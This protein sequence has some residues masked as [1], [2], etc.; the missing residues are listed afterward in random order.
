MDFNELIDRNS[1]EFVRDLKITFFDV[2]AKNQMLMDQI[3]VALSQE[4]NQER[5]DSLQRLW[6]DYHDAVKGCINGTYLVSSSLRQLEECAHTYDNLFAEKTEPIVVKAQ[7]NETHMIE[8]NALEVPVDAINEVSVAEKDVPPIP[9]IKVPSVEEPTML[10]PIESEKLPSVEELEPVVE[11]PTIVQP[12]KIVAPAESEV[13]EEPT[14]V[15]SEEVPVASKNDKPVI[16]STDSSPNI[17][18]VSTEST[19]TPVAEPTLVASEEI[20]IIEQPIVDTL[21]IPV[22]EDVQTESV[23]KSNEKVQVDVPEI[24]ANEEVTPTE[25]IK[26]DMFSAPVEKALNSM[27]DSPAEAAGTGMFAPPTEAAGTGMFASPTEAAGTGMFAS[28]TEAVGTGMFA[29]PAV[30]EI[31]SDVLT[32]PELTPEESTETLELES[33]APEPTTDEK[34]EATVTKIEVAATPSLEEDIPPVLEETKPAPEEAKESLLPLIEENQEEEKQP[35]PEKKGLL[36]LA[37]EPE[38]PKDENKELE[39]FVKESFGEGKAILVTKTQA[40]K[41]RYSKDLQTTLVHSIHPVVKK[42][43]VNEEEDVTE[44]QLEDMINQLSSLYEQG[45]MEEAEKMSDRISVLS[46]RLKPAA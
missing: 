2:A 39:T 3:E 17:E 32:P 43:D 13:L 6:A 36:E 34:A 26:S 38:K 4:T 25:N 42:E 22:E 10:P 35:E 23:E 11:E 9:S 7:P 1:D 8:D 20:P 24:V 31:K 45:K 27:L 33:I 46:K 41:L 5:I 14:L 30:E 40:Q 15:S 29:P 37:P 16:V 28:P 18:V 44:E 19:A 12:T 21:K